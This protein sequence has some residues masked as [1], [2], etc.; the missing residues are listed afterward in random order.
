MMSFDLEREQ[1]QLRQEESYRDDDRNARTL[2]RETGLRVVPPVMR[3]GARLQEHKTAGPLS[4]YIL[5]GRIRLSTPDE[6]V[7]LPVGH[8]VMLGG[9]FAHDVEAIGESP[10]LL[11]IRTT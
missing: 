4:I 10:F 2:V 11:T 1:E 7:D 9:N 8:V 5:A 6:T 3:S